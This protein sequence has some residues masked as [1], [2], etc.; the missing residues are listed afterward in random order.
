MRAYQRW[1]DRYAEDLRA[2]HPRMTAPEALSLAR[3]RAQERRRGVVRNTLRA[4]GWPSWAAEGMSRIWPGFLLP[5][6]TQGDR[7]GS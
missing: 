3:R 1:I 7:N 4:H 5:D 6:F 2:V